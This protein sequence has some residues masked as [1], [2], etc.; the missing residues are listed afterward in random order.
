MNFDQLTDKLSG[1]DTYYQSELV[2]VLDDLER[3]R[4]QAFSTFVIVVMI[5]AAVMIS[6]VI[7]TRNMQLIIFSIFP[8]SIIIGY[9]YKKI[10]SIKNQAKQVIMPELCRRFG[11]T[12]TIKPN[13]RLIEEYRELSLVPGFDE[14]TLEDEINGQAEGIE[15][16][17]F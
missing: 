8:A 12:Y 2:A 7:I 4:K 13:D 15:F 10:T 3:K 1:F 17:L 9:F 5:V 11:M 16:N 14:K 6:L